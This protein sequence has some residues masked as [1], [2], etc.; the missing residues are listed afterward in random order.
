MEPSRGARIVEATACA[1]RIPLAIDHGARLAPRKDTASVD[2]VEDAHE[3]LETEPE[4]SCLVVRDCRAAILAAVRVK[5]HE[6]RR[7]TSLRLEPRWAPRAPPTTPA[8]L[9]PRISHAQEL[10]A[11]KLDELQQDIG[12]L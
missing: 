2:T 11:A 6:R 8:R 12:A 5:L 7:S 3:I 1:R 10:K 4:D 9:C